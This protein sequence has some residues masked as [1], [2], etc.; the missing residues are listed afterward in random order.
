VALGANYLLS[1]MY[2]RLFTYKKSDQSRKLVTEVKYVWHFTSTSPTCLHGAAFRFVGHGPLGCECGRD[3]LKMKAVR[4]SD[5][6]VSYHITV[7]H[8]I[9]EDH[10]LNF[11]R[12]KNLKSH[13]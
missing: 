10:D 4:S 5:T 12:H 1:N 2:W 8:H 11:Y 3:T 6:L 13:L 9:P 7:W